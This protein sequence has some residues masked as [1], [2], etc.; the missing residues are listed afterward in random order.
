M[1]QILVRDGDLDVDRLGEAPQ[2]RAQHDP[3]TGGAPP[4]G[5][6]ALA[7]HPTS[8][9]QRA[10]GLDRIPQAPHLNLAHPGRSPNRVVPRR[11]M[12]LPSST[13]TA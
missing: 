2:P 11:T 13:A 10:H 5:L 8:P 3:R 6:R 9:A 4:C 7:A 1:G 12:V